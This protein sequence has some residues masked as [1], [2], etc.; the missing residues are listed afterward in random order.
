[1]VVKMY[2]LSWQ[3]EHGAGSGV[4]AIDSADENKS[5]SVYD[6]ADSIVYNDDYDEDE[7]WSSDYVLT[8][9]QGNDKTDY[10]KMALEKAIIMKAVRKQ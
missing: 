7:I 6:V 9:D 10:F 1:M 4:F 5:L 8:D 3:N 2:N